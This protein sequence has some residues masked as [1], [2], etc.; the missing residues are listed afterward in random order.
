M[1][2][3]NSGADTVV[4]VDQHVI[5]LK[6]GQI[7]PPVVLGADYNIRAACRPNPTFEAELSLASPTEALFSFLSQPLAPGLLGFRYC[8]K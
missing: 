6:R 5:S 1:Q 2:K 8:E 7:E 4:A 3:A